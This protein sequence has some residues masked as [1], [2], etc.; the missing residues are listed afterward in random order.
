MKG[1][2]I[3]FKSNS[4]QTDDFEWRIGGNVTFQRFTNHKIDYYATVSG[5]CLGGVEGATGSD[6][7]SGAE[8]LRVLFCGRSCG[9][10]VDFR[11]SLSSD[12][13]VATKVHRFHSLQLM[14]SGLIL[15]VKT[16]QKL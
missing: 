9:V 13:W 8:L 14:F 1:I 6:S 16:L 7:K 15:S 3:A 12:G 5:Y 2:E 10:D 4:V 11:W